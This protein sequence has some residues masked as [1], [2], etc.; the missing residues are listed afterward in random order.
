MSGESWDEESPEGGRPGARRKGHRQLVLRRVHEH[1]K[2]RG[3]AGEAGSSRMR[4]PVLYKAL[5]F[6]LPAILGFISF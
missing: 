4:T 1:A 3:T 6:Q 5:S 2:T